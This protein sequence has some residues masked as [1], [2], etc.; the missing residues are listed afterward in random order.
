VRGEGSYVWDADGRATST[1][2][3]ALRGARRARAPAARRGDPRAGR[4]LLFYSNVVYSDVRALAAERVAALAPEGLRR[5]FFCNSGT[6]AN[7]TALKL[8][9]KRPGRKRV[10]SMREASTA[11]RSARSARRAWASTATRLPAAAEHA[12][13]PYGDLP[14][15]QAA[16]E[17]RRGATAERRRRGDPRAD[18]VDGRHPRRARRYFAA[19]RALCDQ[20]GALLVFDEVQTGFGRTGHAVL[21][22]GRGRAPDLIA[23]AKG[24]GGGVPRAWSSCARTSRPRCTRRPGHDLRRRPLACAAMATIAQLIARRTCPAT[25]ARVGGHLAA[26]GAT[27]RGVPRSAAAGLMLGV[28][29]DRPAPSRDRRCAAGVLTAAARATPADPAAAAA[30]ADR[31]E[32]D[33][34]VAA[35]SGARVTSRSDAGLPRRP[36][37]PQAS[38]PRRRPR[39]LERPLAPALAADLRAAEWNTLLAQAER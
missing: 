7:E 3:R 37:A 33:E 20:R 10:S 2:R 18:P 31:A 39:R 38:R 30:H 15:L 9:R 29:L 35:S 19:L 11:A 17:P 27:L 22:R 4:A 23:G 26:A 14:A 5:V 12:F 6:E 28:N 25:R 34:C 36:R 1:V 13:V 24:A 16:F 8:A 21:R 32:A